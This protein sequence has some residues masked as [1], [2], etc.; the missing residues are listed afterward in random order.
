MKRLKKNSLKALSMLAVLLLCIAV[1]A[2]CDSKKEPSIADISALDKVFDG[3]AIDF[4]PS[5]S[6]GD[7]ELTVE[8]YRGDEKLSQAPTE[9]GE[10]KLVI[11]VAESE[12]FKAA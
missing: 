3:Q 11:I 8:W 10:Y 9:A 6:E 2:A 1:F 12:N 4:V 5:L 7:G